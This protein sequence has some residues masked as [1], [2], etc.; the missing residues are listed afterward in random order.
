MFPHFYIYYIPRG[1]LGIYW[2]WPCCKSSNR[3]YS[4]TE[5]QNSLETL[6]VFRYQ[7]VMICIWWP[8]VTTQFWLKVEERSNLSTRSRNFSF[9]K[10]NLLKYFADTLRVIVLDPWVR[11][12]C[13]NSLFSHVCQYVWYSDIN[14]IGQIMIFLN[15]IYKQSY[16]SMA[17]SPLEPMR[18][19]S[20][21][22]TLYYPLMFGV[23][24]LL[25]AHCSSI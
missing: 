16:C 21:I 11:R 9:H 24:Q 5:T 2:F 18:I 8:S 7:Y 3:D 25:A 19:K 14:N 6:Q 10:N 4:K 23:S 12:H 20:I 13:T 15:L 1:G 17:Q 22:H